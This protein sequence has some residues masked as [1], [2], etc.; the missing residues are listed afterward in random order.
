MKTGVFIV[1][2]ARGSIIDEDALVEALKSGKGERS[3]LVHLKRC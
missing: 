1:N 3:P 2:T